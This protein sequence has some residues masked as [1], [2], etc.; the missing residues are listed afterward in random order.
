LIRRLLFRVS[1]VVASAYDAGDTT[2]RRRARAALREIAHRRAHAGG[3]RMGEIEERR[4]NR[5]LGSFAVAEGERGIR[6][7]DGQYDVCRKPSGW[8]NRASR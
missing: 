8:K 2:F 6:R 7:L 3:E 5:A 1:A 4:A